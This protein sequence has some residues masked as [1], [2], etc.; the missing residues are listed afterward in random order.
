[1]KLDG[2]FNEPMAEPGETAANGG[3][4]G[5]LGTLWLW[6]RWPLA[7]Y[8]I[9]MLLMMFAEPYLAFVPVRLESA[10]RPPR[11]D[12]ELAEIAT[13][14]GLTLYGWY[15]P[16]EQPRA[17]VVYHHGNGGNI[18]HREEILDDL[19]R[20]GVA[21]LVYD[22]RG[23]GWS[24]GTPSEAGVLQ[25]GRAATRWLAEREN[26]E[27]DRIVQM[28]RSL[29]GAVAVDVAVEGA[30]GVILVSTFTSM[31][32]AAAYHYPWLPVH[33]LMRTRLNSLAK[34]DRIDGP[35]LIGHFVADEVV[36]Y[37]LGERLFAAATAEPKR[38]VPFATG[39]HND[40]P[41]GVWQE[42]LE[43]FFGRFDREPSD[44]AAEPAAASPARP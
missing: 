38:F 5:L 30:A 3:Y 8:L 6:A 34:I 10:P 42:A 25:D 4:W 12:V 7:A 14:D 37:P 1:M 17:Y 2:S 41:S 18:L 32:D 33:L 9:V 13:P 26:I 24:E 43:E 27:A 44:P 23:Y 11:P 39:F 22:Y 36:P 29:G 16:H 15:L 31:P 28:G 20:L 19:H 40:R 21:V 35:L